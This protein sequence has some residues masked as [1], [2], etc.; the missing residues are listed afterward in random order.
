MDGQTIGTPVDTM[1]DI[2][3]LHFVKPV[4]ERY[5]PISYA[6]MAHVHN[7]VTNHGG[8]AVS[9]RHS[10]ELAFILRAKDLAVDIRDACR[11][12]IRY[13]ARLAQVEMGKLHDFRLQ[14]APP[15][16]IAQVDLV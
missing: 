1:F 16:Y 7:T 2:Q 10:R 4:L 8:A 5:S 12:C 15:F 9:V 14:I 11:P 3:P 13:K 6:I